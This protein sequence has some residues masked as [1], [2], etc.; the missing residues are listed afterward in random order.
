M[1]PTSDTQVVEI[2]GRNWLVN[3][4][5]TAGIEVA[6]PERDKGID[7]IAY[8]DTENRFGAVP[9]QMKASSAHSFSVSRKYSSFAFSNNSFLNVYVCNLQAEGATETYALT[10]TETV[11]VAEEMGWT[12]TS[13]WLDKGYYRTGKFSQKLET[14]L[15]PYRM[16]T[17]KWQQRILEIINHGTH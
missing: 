11:S 8:I 7:L 12:Q 13:S 15:I 16:T 10:Q 6:R 5:F 9:I 4:L 14:L 2:M 3:A 1:T 17:E